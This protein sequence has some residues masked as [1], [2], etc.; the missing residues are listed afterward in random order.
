MPPP[1]LPRKADDGL[2]FRLD[3]VTYSV[4]VRHGVMAIERELF[5]QT[6]FTLSQLFEAISA[7]ATFAVP[8]LVFLAR[9][10]AGEAVKYAA[11]EADIERRAADGDL[12]LELLTDEE[13]TADPPA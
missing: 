6:G 4:S 5:Q 10:Q 7:G 8:A 3:G 9:R 2:S 1:Q 11:I 12:E 13:A